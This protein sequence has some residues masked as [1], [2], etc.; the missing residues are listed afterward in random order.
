MLYESQ[1][2]MSV[3]AT[4]G[5]HFLIHIIFQAFNV[6]SNSFRIIPHNQL[7][8]LLTY[9]LHLHHQCHPLPVEIIVKYSI[10]FIFF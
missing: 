10:N 9:Q 1:E 6:L 4:R 5:F 3:S 7:T 2:K 8:V